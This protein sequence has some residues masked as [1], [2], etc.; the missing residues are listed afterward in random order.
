MSTHFMEPKGRHK[1]LCE[2]IPSHHLM[3]VGGDGPRSLVS[4]I[5]KTGARSKAVLDEVK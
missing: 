2:L 5:L 4:D 1:V 3:I